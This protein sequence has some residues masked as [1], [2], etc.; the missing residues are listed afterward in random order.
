MAGV[1]LMERPISS[2]ECVQDAWTKVLAD[3]RAWCKAET[4][5]TRAWKHR[6]FK[7][8]IAGCRASMVDDAEAM[9]A[10][11][12]KNENT[13]VEDGGTAFI[14]VML[15]A[16]A[17]ATQPPEISQIIGRPY[18]TDVLIN[19]DGEDKIVQMRTIPK[20]IR[21]QVVYIST[22]PHDAQ[23]ISDQ[24]CAYMTDDAKRKF[25]VFY[26]GF[27]EPFEMTVLDNSL[28]PDIVPTEAKNLS[29]VSID[30]TMIGLVPQLHDQDTDVG[31]NPETGDLN[32]DYVHD[33]K[34]VITAD[35]QDQDT[36]QHHQVN[37]DPDSG[38]ITV[39][40]II[41]P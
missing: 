11:W 41:D 8:A 17:V 19:T 40:E 6:P 2:L 20:A 37:A 34:V 36:T 28:F 1:R 35:L 23:S 7:E 30:V 9:L 33:Y 38:D 27:A 32:S 26:N 13:D 3:F 39:T 22:N 4:L 15:T 18:W 16:T 29:M 21:A 12:R 10:S 24:F 14:P 31:F 25:P 5:H